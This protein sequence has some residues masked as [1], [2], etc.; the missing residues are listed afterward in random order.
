MSEKGIGNISAIT[1]DVLRASLS[2]A[3]LP[4]TPT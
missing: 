3:M 1:L 2:A 4:F